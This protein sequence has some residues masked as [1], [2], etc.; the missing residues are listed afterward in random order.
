M[1]PKLKPRDPDR[2]DKHTEFWA[3]IL[4]LAMIVVLILLRLFKRIT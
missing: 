1:N 3:S 4:C 2:N